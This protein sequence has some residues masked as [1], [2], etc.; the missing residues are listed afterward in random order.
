MKIGQN[1]LLLHLKQIRRKLSYFPM[2]RSE[3]KL[4][5]VGGRMQCCSIVH[6]VD[7]SSDYDAHMG[8]DLGSLVCLR[9]FLYIDSSVK[10][11]IYL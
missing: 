1:F 4:I 8:S 9:H 11:E 10:F 6:I 5:K 7:G 2:Q 3:K